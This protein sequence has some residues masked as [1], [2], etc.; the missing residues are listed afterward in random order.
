MA[1]FRIRRNAGGALTNDSGT[2]DLNPTVSNIFTL[3]L[4]WALASTPALVFALGL[5]KR[6]INKD[7]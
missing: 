6:Y 2:P 3:I 1:R 7:P 5:L 4:A